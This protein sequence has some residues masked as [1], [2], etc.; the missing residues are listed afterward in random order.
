MTTEARGEPEPPRRP[1]ARTSSDG[2]AEKEREVDA[3]RH[4]EHVDDPTCGQV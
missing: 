1:E 2:A 4:S 3:T